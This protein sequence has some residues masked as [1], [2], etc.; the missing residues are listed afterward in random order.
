[1]CRGYLE[2]SNTTSVLQL[3]FASSRIKVSEPIMCLVKNL[4]KDG[5]TF[6]CN[7]KERM[8]EELMVTWLREVWGRSPSALQKKRKLLSKVT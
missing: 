1:V 2:P 6:K 4:L 7:E 8:A 3:I 5:I